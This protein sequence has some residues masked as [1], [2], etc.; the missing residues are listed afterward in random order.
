MCNIIIGR[1]QTQDTAG[2][3][4]RRSWSSYTDFGRLTQE[5]IQCINDWMILPDFVVPSISDPC[6]DLELT[7]TS[8]RF[9]KSANL[10]SHVMIDHPDD[11]FTE[12]STTA[13]AYRH[14]KLQSRPGVVKL[15]TVSSVEN[16]ARLFVNLT[17]RGCKIQAAP[18]VDFL[19]ESITD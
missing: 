6:K 11:D 3:A 17:A 5:E 16:V 10:E 15:E 14:Q 8:A 4:S 12:E 9:E 2:T 18:L 13:S 1:R 7:E 19:E